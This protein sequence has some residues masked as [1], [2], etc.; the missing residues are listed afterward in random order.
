[1]RMKRNDIRA[2]FHFGFQRYKTHAEKVGIVALICDEQR[3]RRVLGDDGALAPGAI[4]EGGT[5]PP[6]SHPPSKTTRACVC[7]WYSCCLGTNER[8]KPRV[9]TSAGQGA[10]LGETPA[11]VVLCL[12]GQ[13]GSSG[14]W[15][16]WR[17][18]SHC[19]QRRPDSSQVHIKPGAADRGSGAYGPDDLPDNT[20]RNRVHEESFGRVGVIGHRERLV[21]EHGNVE[22]SAQTAGIQEGEL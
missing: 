10:M 19:I 5:P 8:R 13:G 4:T 7:V 9:H 17:W 6:L 22:V 15:W 11:N 18:C 16:W 12:R 20:T 3:C 2:S 1:M 14:R 21:Q